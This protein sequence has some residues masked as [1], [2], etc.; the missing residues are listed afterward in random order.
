VLRELF[1]LLEGT[2]AEA[3]ADDAPPGTVRPL[4]RRGSG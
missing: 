3:Q 1:G 4:R 2:G